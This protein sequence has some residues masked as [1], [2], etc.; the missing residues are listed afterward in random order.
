MT[1]RLVA[2]VVTLL[3]ALATLAGPVAAA[4]SAQPYGAQAICRYTRTEGGKYGWT[5]AVFKKIV[6]KPPTLFSNSGASQRVG[7]QFVVSRSIFNEDGFGPWQVTYSSPIQKA[8]ATPTK[9]AALSKLTVGVTVPV[10]GQFE[11]VFY[12]VGLKA[13]WYAPNGK[14]QSKTSYV[15]PTYGMFV[16]KHDQGADAIDHYCPGLALQFYPH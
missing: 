11:S 9:A 1:G 10:V 14:V 5:E 15:F 13:L 16:G 2:T 7:W 4:Q 3:V 8:T 6:V 12:Q